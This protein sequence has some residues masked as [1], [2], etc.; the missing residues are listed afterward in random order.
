[1]DPVKL[2]KI[3]GWK[4]LWEK[5]IFPWHKDGINPKLEKYWSI[6]LQAAGKSKPEECRFFVPLCGK[7]KDLLFL[8]S[9]GFQVI[10]CEGVHQACTDFFT[11]NSINDME[12]VELEP[13]MTSYS[14]K[15]GKL[16]II[17]GDYFKLTPN[18]LGGKVDC[19]WDRGSLVAIDLG[20]REKYADVMCSVLN[21][22]FGYLIA[23]IEREV[24][25]PGCMPYSLS[26]D[27][28]K[29]LF[30]K[31]FGVH[32][33]ESKSDENK[34]KDNTFIVST[35]KG[36]DGS[37]LE[38]RL[39][40]WRGRWDKSMIGWHKS[41]VNEHLTQYYD[42]LLNGKEKIKILFPLSG[43]S[44]DLVHCYNQG[45]I[46]VGIEGVPLAVEEMFQNGNLKYSRTFCIEIDGFIYQTEDGRLSVYCCDFFKMKPELIGEDKCDSVF[47]RGAF[48][49]IFEAD[50]ESYAKLILQFVKPDFRYILNI[51][52]YGGDYKGP[53]R[54][55][56]KEE[57]F[58]LFNGHKMGSNVVS[59]AELLM[60]EDALDLFK[61]KGW[62]VDYAIKNIYGI[63][64]IA[65]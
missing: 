53:P 14:T 41:V 31:K 18:L 43:K 19:V 13:G 21:N 60:Q 20:D 55:A 9:Q 15:D 8:R 65:P 1:M 39:N 7:T 47:D 42:Y 28:V 44:I 5:G 26:F 51:Y 61:Q 57:I 33:M 56:K 11:E 62:E 32:L 27:D 10:G 16:K 24:D 49:A 22:Q 48:E 52:D 38:D 59:K 29:D 37:S 64:S 12:K 50:R 35:D 23:S 25:S 54:A 17:G 36:K 45:H 4:D 40:M 30:G 6:L 3:D 34:V 63:K 46:V 58:G 2:K